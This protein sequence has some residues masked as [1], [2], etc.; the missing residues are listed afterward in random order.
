LKPQTKSLENNKIMGWA[1]GKA[2]NFL[3]EAEEEDDEGGRC[4]RRC[5]FIGLRV[6]QHAAIYRVWGSDLIIHIN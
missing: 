4:H 3:L 5:T 2:I 1:G 6:P